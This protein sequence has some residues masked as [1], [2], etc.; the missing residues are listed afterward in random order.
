MSYS[1]GCRHSLVPALLWLWCRP[2]ARAPIQPLAWEPLCAMDVALK[3]QKK[4][5]I[6]EDTNGKTSHAHGLEEYC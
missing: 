6:E 5:E 1:V 2:E 3:D 4:K